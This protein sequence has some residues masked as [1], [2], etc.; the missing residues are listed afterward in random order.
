[1]DNKLDIENLDNDKD[2]LLKKQSQIVKLV[3]K[4]RLLVKISKHMC[5]SLVLI[6]IGIIVE[7]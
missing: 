4:D 1:M 2:L 5:V 3:K 7:P 6:L